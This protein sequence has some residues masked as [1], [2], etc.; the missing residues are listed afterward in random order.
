MVKESFR[1]TLVGSKLATILDAPAFLRSED[2]RLQ[3]EFDKMLYDITTT[4]LDEATSDHFLKAAQ[5]SLDLVQG[6]TQVLYASKPNTLRNIAMEVLRT[7]EL[8]DENN[9]RP[10]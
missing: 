8:S 9:V 5:I 7:K 6:D 4:Q 10:R 3:V 2:A 1:R